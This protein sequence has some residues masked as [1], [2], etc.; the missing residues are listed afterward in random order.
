LP[1]TLD[2]ATI[3]QRSN[4]APIYDKTYL[5][6]LKASTP[7]SRPP[8]LPENDSIDVDMSI[9]VDEFPTKIIDVL[10]TQGNSEHLALPH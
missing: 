1:S 6:E 10:E 4:G 7:S 8:P 2:Q 3:S 5:S 9:D